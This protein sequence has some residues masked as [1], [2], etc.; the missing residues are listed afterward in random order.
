MHLVEKEDEDA[1]TN[2]SIS[3]KSKVVTVCDFLSRFIHFQLNKRE[4][5]DVNEEIIVKDL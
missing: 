1:H 5:H 3:I 4:W 2:F